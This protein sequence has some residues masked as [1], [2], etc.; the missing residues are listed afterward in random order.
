MYSYW[1]KESEAGRVEMMTATFYQV[2]W[3]L[4]CE[5]DENVNR[6][7]FQLNSCIKLSFDLSMRMN[8]WLQL[9][10]IRHF[11]KKCFSQF[12]SF[13]LNAEHFYSRQM[14]ICYTVEMS[15]CFSCYSNV[16][17]RQMFSILC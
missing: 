1:T 17:K 9:L 4:D 10:S 8:L 7:T 11:G 6:I 5:F 2:Q 12:L 13:F 16:Y 14:S 3:T 15:N